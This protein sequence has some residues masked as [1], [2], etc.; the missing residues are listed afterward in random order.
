MRTY[1]KHT[2]DWFGSEDHWRAD[3]EKLKKHKVDMGAVWK[4]RGLPAFV[5]KPRG[6]NQLEAEAEDEDR[7]DYEVSGL[8][9][10]SDGD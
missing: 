9:Y 1:A 3:C 4:K 6:V 8:M 10:D 5:P 7:G 2:P